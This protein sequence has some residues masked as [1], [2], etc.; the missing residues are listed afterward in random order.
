MMA[1][2]IG[3]LLRQSTCFE[4]FISKAP[5]PSH[6][7]YRPLSQSASVEAQ[8][9]PSKTVPRVLRDVPLPILLR[10]L[11]V[12]SVAALPQSIL[13][14]IIKTTKKYSR[15][16]SA[17]SALR[18]PVHST[19]YKTFCIGSQKHDIRENIKALRGMGLNGIVLAFAR[20]TKIGS[21]DQDC[22]L[23]AS[24]S[25]LREWVSMNLETLENLTQDDYLAL[26]CTGAGPAAVAALDDFSASLP[27]SEGYA[28]KL[29]RLD[30]FEDAL[31]EICTEAERRG[32][33][34]LVDAESSRHQAGIDHA[35]LVRDWRH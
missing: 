5:T 32:V 17:S 35:T 9:Q 18:W 30:I 1:T 33:R 21:P 29:Q 13:S 26:R 20:E 22:R 4:N 2:R 11:V 31:M 15:F 23:V 19:F 14:V 10:S 28:E 34:V 27:D 3:L 24:D 12:L 25:P 8:K 7:F 16:I 6:T